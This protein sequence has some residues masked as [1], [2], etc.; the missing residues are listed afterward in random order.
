MTEEQYNKC[1]E[2]LATIKQ[3]Y[4][5]LF[6]S[7]NELLTNYKKVCGELVSINSRHEREID[8]MKA[9]ACEDL[10]EKLIPVY[11]NLDLAVANTEK[12]PFAEG[13]KFIANDFRK[14]LETNG[15]ETIDALPHQVFD[16][17]I[18]EAIAAVPNRE[19]EPES[20]IRQF[21]IGWKLGNKV[22][23]PAQVIV[24]ASV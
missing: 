23:R 8:E 10:L 5:T 24:A 11:D 2:D 3:D 17:T 19:Y 16:P 12:T 4:M 9:R 18:H 14:V 7:Y 22:V 1:I 6:D 20:I 15:V 13:V 21:R